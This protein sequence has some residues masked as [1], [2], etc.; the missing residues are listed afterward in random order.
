M[1]M[2]MN[3]RTTPI[4]C[5]LALLSGLASCASPPPSV[6]TPAP[7][8]SVKLEYHYDD[9]RFR[10]T[11]LGFTGDVKAKLRSIEINIV[12][13]TLTI[14]NELRRHDLL[15]NESPWLLAVTV[16]DLY[17]GPLY[18]TAFVTFRTEADRIGGKVE[19]VGADGEAVNSFDVAIS[20][21]TKEAIKGG[22][23]GRLTRLYELFAGQ[24]VA[25]LPTE[26]G[27]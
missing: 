7:Q 17:L 15:E 22:K 13:L 23:Q 10:G 14:Q 27:R 6:T 21:D 24:V 3:H 16:E 1:I 2:I 11:N 5:L 20:T 8:D 9:Q 4:I 25:G 18:E 26:R 19:I 12:D